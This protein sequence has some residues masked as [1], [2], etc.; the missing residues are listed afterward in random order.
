M[1]FIDARQLLF[2]SNHGGNMVCGGNVLH[3]KKSP[4]WSGRLPMML[5]LSERSNAK[6]DAVTLSAA[7][8]HLVLCA[9][10]LFLLSTKF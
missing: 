7:T 1:A 4:S 8:L 5:L 9:R 10:L 6:V 3:K 2:M